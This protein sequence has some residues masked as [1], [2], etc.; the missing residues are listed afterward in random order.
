MQ[1]KL[2]FKYEQR[3]NKVAVLLTTQ[4]HFGNDFSDVGREIEV[5]NGRVRSAGGLCTHMASINELVVPGDQNLLDMD[6]NM[7]LEKDWFDEMATLAIGYNQE[8]SNNSR[9]EMDDV[10]EKRTGLFEEVAG[11]SHWNQSR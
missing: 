10:F 2:F 1:R 5:E 3:K 7:I 11:R 8:Y 6:R 9:V 4:T